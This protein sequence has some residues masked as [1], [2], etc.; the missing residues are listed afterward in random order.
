MRPPLEVANIFRQ[1]GPDFRFTHTLLP[2]Q[3]RVMRAFHYALSAHGFLALG[4]A[5]SVGGASDMFDLLDKRH[6]IYSRRALA[7]VTALVA[8]KS[9]LTWLGT[10][11][12]NSSSI[13]T[14]EQSC[15]DVQ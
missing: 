12:F 5:E 9:L 7:S 8:I 3:R 2:E 1:H 13:A 15:P 14:A 4:L 11:A 6:R 10:P